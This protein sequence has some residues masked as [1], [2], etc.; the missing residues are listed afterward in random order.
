MGIFGDIWEAIKKAGRGIVNFFKKIF[1]FF[2][3]GVKF[4]VEGIFKALTSL[5]K[6]HWIGTLID[7]IQ[8]IIELIKFFKSKGADVD[9]SYKD[10]IQDMNIYS[11]GEHQINIEVSP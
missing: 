10:K 8:L 11:E 3:N 1:S 4:I 6:N 5:L 7:G 2:F 9:E